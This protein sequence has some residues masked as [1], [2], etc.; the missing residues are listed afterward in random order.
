MEYFVIKNKI[1][2]Y[3]INKALINVYRNIQ[4]KGIKASKQPKITKKKRKQEKQNN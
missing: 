3:D 1:Y 2:A 4:K